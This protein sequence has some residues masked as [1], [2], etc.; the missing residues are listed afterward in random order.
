MRCR[1]G[2]GRANDGWSTDSDLER[3]RCSRDWRNW[4]YLEVGVCGE[5]GA[6]GSMALLVGPVDVVVGADGLGVAD[7]AV[8]FY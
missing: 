7:A 8:V 6:G 5:V 2:E 1:G 4:G 3:S